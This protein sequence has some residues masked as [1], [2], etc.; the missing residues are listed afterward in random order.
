MSKI[1][2][3]LKNII[4]I[5][6]FLS[7]Y[8]PLFMILIFQNMNNKFVALFYIILI[9]ISLIILS[10]YCENYADRTKDTKIT[11]KDVKNNGVENLGYMSGYVIPFVSINTAIIVDGKFSIQNTATVLIL[12]SVLGYL[13]IKSN[14]YYVNPVL[15][16]FYDIDTIT[17][18]E[19]GD[20]ILIRDKSYKF[21][22]GNNFNVVHGIDNIYFVNDKKNTVVKM[23]FIAIIAGITFFTFI[24]WDQ[25]KDIIL[26]FI[27][28]IV[29]NAL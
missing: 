2:I 17:T 24:F 12:F 20:I 8:I 3:L 22:I 18:K 4:K 19:V 1:D 7:S 9:V 21:K 23:I 15:N 26:I 27:A 25:I 29:K 28:N 14:L 13:Y 6:L 11:V 10:M 16:L 5:F